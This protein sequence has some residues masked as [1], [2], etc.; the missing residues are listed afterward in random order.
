MISLYFHLGVDL[1]L[2]GK[3]VCVSQALG[4]KIAKV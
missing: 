1:H 4:N 3:A 2:V